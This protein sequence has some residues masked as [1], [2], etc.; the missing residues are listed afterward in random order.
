M[1]GLAKAAKET[2][3]FLYSLKD[4]VLSRLLAQERAR[5][6]G[7]HSKPDP[8]DAV[9][10]VRRW[11]PDR[12]QYQDEIDDDEFDAP[13]LGEWIAI[14][15]KDV[16]VDNEGYPIVLSPATTKCYVRRKDAEH[17]LREYMRLTDLLIQADARCTIFRSERVE[18]HCHDDGRIRSRHRI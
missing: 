7:Y 8:W 4:E 15:N 12:Y 10:F 1:H 18:G 2:K 13:S 17:T 6:V 14:P 9:H 11:A 3:E 5:V 16:T